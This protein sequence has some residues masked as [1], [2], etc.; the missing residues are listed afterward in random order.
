MNRCRGLFSILILSSLC[1]SP[2]LAAER[3]PEAL[4]LPCN[5]CHGPDGVSQ[6][7]SIPSIAGLNAEYQYQAML[8]FKEGR[9][10][11][12]IMMR[13][14]KGYKDSELRKIA[15]YFAARPWTAVAPAGDTEQVERGRKVH[16]AL[17]L[18]CHEDMGRYQDKDVPRLAGQ[19]S[20]Y[21]RLQMTAYLK[22]TEKMPQP[23]E[24]AEKLEQTEPGDVEALS[25]FYASVR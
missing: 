23:T 14:A 11:S 18:D 6:A 4:A 8:Q 21:L 10:A 15:R 13:I 12:T 7:G 3:R 20:G 19:L 2:L 16:E 9:R 17:C 1:A 22:G 5:G 24:M 25:A